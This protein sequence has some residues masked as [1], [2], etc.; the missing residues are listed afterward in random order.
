MALSPRP[1]FAT[2]ES[3]GQN[4]DSGHGK[5]GKA[6]Q[7]ANNKDSDSRKLTKSSGSSGRGIKVAQYPK[8]PFE[9]VEDIVEHLCD[10]AG[11]MSHTQVGASW[12]TGS[13]NIPLS[14]SHDLLEA[15]LA[16]QQGMLFFR[17][18]Y[19]PTSVF[20]PDDE[21]DVNDEG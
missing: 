20:M 7:R 15:H 21:E 19:V 2:N 10:I 17:V 11:S 9:D 16:G 8:V 3:T 1:S 14:Y 18:Y 5:E 12:M 13:L 4:R 6:R